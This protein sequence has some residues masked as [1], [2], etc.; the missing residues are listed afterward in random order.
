MLGRPLPPRRPTC[1]KSGMI[2]VRKA[3]RE[4]TMS[5]T[6]PHQRQALALVRSR[7]R[8]LTGR[9]R[10]EPAMLVGPDQTC[11]VYLGC[12]DKA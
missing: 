2:A 10:G 6:A 7:S 12:F 8:E 1:P 4:N 5:T 3:H 11:D 9:V